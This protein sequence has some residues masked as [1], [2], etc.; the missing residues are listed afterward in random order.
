MWIARRI[1]WI[2]ANKVEHLAHTLLAGGMVAKLVGEEPL[3]DL[4]AD[5]EARV[6]RSER[7][8]EDDLHALAQR[9]TLSGGE[10]LDLTPVEG[11]G[12]GGGWLQAEG[13]AAERGLAGARL[14]DEAERFAAIH[15]EV[16]AVN[17]ANGERLA[18]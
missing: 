15:G 16:H 13:H 7:I 8:L 14:A 3:F 12:A 5:R 6:Q 18:D 10:L 4:V 2:E 1:V 9:A 17:G 11:D